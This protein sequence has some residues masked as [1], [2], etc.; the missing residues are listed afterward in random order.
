MLKHS[1]I[2][3]YDHDTIAAYSG[4]GWRV[5][6]D[7][8]IGCLMI[9]SF[10]EVQEAIEKRELLKTKSKNLILSTHRKRESK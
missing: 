2:N 7:Y 3:Y 10:E 5:L 1:D 8:T 9:A 4:K 6:D